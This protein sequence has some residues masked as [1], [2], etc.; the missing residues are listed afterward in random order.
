MSVGLD[1]VDHSI[2]IHQLEYVAG[3]KVTFEGAE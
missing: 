2:L 3:V 1:T